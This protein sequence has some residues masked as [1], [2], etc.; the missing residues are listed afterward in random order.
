MDIELTEDEYET[1]LALVYA[2]NW[3]I[4]AARNDHIESYDAVASDIYSQAGEAALEDHVFY[5]E[6]EDRYYPDAPIEE[7]MR[8]FISDYE[9]EAFWDLLI[10][11]L[12]ERDIR[13]EYDQET[14]EEM[15]PME[16]F[17]TLEEHESP[18]V[19]EFREHG[20]E[21][22]TIDDSGG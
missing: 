3:L 16:W 11:R 15:E 18:Y 14:V 19:E 17:E 1:L 22:L 9:E 8:D 13:E 2:G 10:R 20:V 7:K 4:N 12:A 5:D 6:E 21:R